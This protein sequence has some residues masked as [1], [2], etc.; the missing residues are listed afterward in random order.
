M[1]SCH[2]RGVVLKGR[3]VVGANQN[4][5]REMPAGEGQRGGGEVAGAGAL[6]WPG[7]LCSL[8]SHPLFSFLLSRSFRNPS[9]GHSSMM[10]PS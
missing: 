4:L 1:A 2:R 6:E 10:L 7:F 5:P 8:H 3:G 9:A